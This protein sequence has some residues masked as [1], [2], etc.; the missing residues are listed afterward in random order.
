[1]QQHHPPVPERVEDRHARACS[2]RSRSWWISSMRIVARRPQDPGA[3]DAGRDAG[4]Q[5]AGP[6]R[7]AGAAKCAATFS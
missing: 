2:A 7:S 6:V 4:E 3:D 1:M 5:H